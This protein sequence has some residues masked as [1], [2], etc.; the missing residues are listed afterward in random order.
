MSGLIIAQ[1]EKAREAS[2]KIKIVVEGYEG[3]NFVHYGWVRDN[4]TEF[5]IIDLEN[6]NRT[7]TIKI[8]TIKE[9]VVYNED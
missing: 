1:I 9:V 6:K 8:S 3:D 5:V 2:S 7:A 4:D